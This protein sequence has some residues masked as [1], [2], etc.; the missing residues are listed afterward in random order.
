MSGGRFPLAL[1]VLQVLCL[2]LGTDVLPA[3]AL[4]TEAPRADD[5]AESPRGRH[6]IHRGVVRRAFAVLGPTEALVEM[7]A[8]LTAMVVAGWQPGLPFPSGHALHAASGAAFMAVVVGQAANAF[9]CRSRHLGPRRLGW[10]TNRY[11]VSAVVV[12]LAALCGFLFIGPVARVLG[13]SP[14]PIA[15]ALVALL[16][17]PAVLAADALEKSWWRR[18]RPRLA[19]RGDDAQTA[20]RRG[21]QVAAR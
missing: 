21:E 14:L 16:A 3:L 10:F 18:Q 9:A 6:L 4:G 2:D 7:A 13:Q 17:A 15:A 20:S 12:E 11:L 5:I 8:F 19:T 1:G